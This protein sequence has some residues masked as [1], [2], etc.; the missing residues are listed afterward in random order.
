ML[1]DC[2]CVS[3]CQRVMSTLVV[4]QSDYSKSTEHVNAT[5]LNIQCSFF[6]ASLGGEPA[7]EA[8]A[9]CARLANDTM[10]IKNRSVRTGYLYSGQSYGPLGP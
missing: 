5:P 8:P 4:Q 6:G 2:S 7:P 10:P 1:I 3:G 9:G